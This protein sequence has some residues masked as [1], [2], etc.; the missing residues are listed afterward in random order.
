[1]N[2]RPDLLETASLPPLARQFARFCATMDPAA[3]PLVLATLALLA[4]RDVEGDTCLPLRDHAGKPLLT[5]E[6]GQALAVAPDWRRW[7][8]DLDSILIGEAGDY[9]PV[10]LDRDRLY[11]YRHWKEEQVIVAAL[12]QRMDAG[13]IGATESLKHRLAML[14]DTST[15][16]LRARNLGQKLAAAMALTR[17]LAIITGGPGTG[18]TTTVTRILALLLESSHATRI[19]LAAPTGKAAARLAESIN[20]QIEALRGQ[21]DD[22]VL[23]AIPREAAT[24]HRLLGWMPHGFQYNEDNRLPCDC[25]LLDEA[26][27]VDQGLMASLLRA[28]PAACRLI[29]LGDRDQL[30]SVEAGSVLG[31]ITG[32]GVNLTLSP[33]RAAEMATLLGEETLPVSCSPTPPPIADHISHLEYSHRFAR[34]GGIGRLSQAVNRGDASGALAILSSNEPELEWIEAAEHQAD[35]R[36]VDW[37]V[38]HYAPIFTAGDASEALERFESGRVLTALRQGPWGET[39]LGG[40]IEARLRDTGLIPAVPDE[41]YQGKPVIIQRNDRE[42]GLFN[43]DTGIFWPDDD[44]ALMAWFRGEDG[45]LRS[46]SIHQLPH[47]KTAWTLTVHRSQG[48]QY[49]HVLLV[50]P[51]DE[52]P[53]V[54]RELIYTGITRAG[55]HC[56]VLASRTGFARAIETCQKRHSGLAGRLGWPGY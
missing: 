17:G 26:S 4:Q 13:A 51:P 28:L 49:R 44:Q 54:T 52:S 20:G 16:E 34:G 37:A 30:Q 27:M 18:K 53:V 14:F 23:G 8:A 48:S 38:K 33:G 36:L 35:G 40:Q 15:P 47:W 10:I 21:V 42:T 55:V 9:Q 19:M 56:T 11:L 12:R 7:Q 39:A 2:T 41:I 29:M 6:Q 46:F 25:L 31:D 22:A 24:L 32:H 5:S 43:G 45:T 1:M 3:S 50:L